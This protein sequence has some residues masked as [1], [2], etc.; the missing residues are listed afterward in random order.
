MDERVIKFIGEAFG[1]MN[2]VKLSQGAI[3]LVVSISLLIIMKIGF[4]R[5]KNN[6]DLK[7]DLRKT[8][9]ITTIYRFLLAAVI[10][11]TIMVIMGING[12]N[13][14]AFLVCIGGSVTIIAFTIKDALQDIF[15]GFTIIMD[16]YY[17]VGDA[18]EFEGKDGIVISFT[19]RTTKIEYLDDRSVISVSNRH[20]TK[21]KRLTHLVDVNIPLSYELERETAFRVLGDICNTIKGIDGIEDCM[22]KGTQSFEEYAVIYKVRFFCEPNDRPDIRREVMKTIQDGLASEGI[23]IPYKQID[24]HSYEHIQMSK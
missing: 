14:N 11:A 6:I 21:I 18:V 15:A 3:V 7:G 19:V 1:K 8:H 17:S 13:I 12:I 22:L 10:I 16:K 4:K 20:I 23:S 24:I 5:F 2:F 9:I